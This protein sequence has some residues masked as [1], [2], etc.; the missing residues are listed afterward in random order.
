MTIKT[1]KTDKIALQNAEF[2]ALRN[3]SKAYSN[4]CQTPIV[5]D[6]YPEMR[7]Y[8]ESNLRSFI[9]ALKDNGT[10][11]EAEVTK[12]PLM[13]DF[14]R[15]IPANLHWLIRTDEE[16]GY[17]VNITDTSFNLSLGRE[18][19]SSRAYGA[20]IEEALSKALSNLPQGVSK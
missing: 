2:A 12:A 11:A 1:D 6:D 14:I 7:H 20:T 15:Q 3:L 5:D 4:L 13:S 16:K 9:Q 8:Y 19:F 17:F 10:F 18:G